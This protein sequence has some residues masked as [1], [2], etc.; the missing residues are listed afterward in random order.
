MGL[1][2]YHSLAGDDS[3]G[4]G[5]CNAHRPALRMRGPCWPGA[6]EGRDKGCTQV[7][8]MQVREVPAGRKVQQTLPGSRDEPLPTPSS[9]LTG[10]TA[11]AATYSSPSHRLQL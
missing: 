11:L 1:G 2:A 9:F 5:L 7:C 4:T 10:S 6:W 3:A 8:C